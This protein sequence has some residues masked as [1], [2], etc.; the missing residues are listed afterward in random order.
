MN[1][2]S[3]SDL[4]SFGSTDYKADFDEWQ[5]GSFRLQADFHEAHHIV[6]GG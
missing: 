3:L 1:I 6:G 5:S 4:P 2:G